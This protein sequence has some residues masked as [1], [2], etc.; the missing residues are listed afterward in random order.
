MVCYLIIAQLRCY[1]IYIE[2][3]N[4]VSCWV[5]RLRKKKIMCEFAELLIWKDSSFDP[6][7]LRLQVNLKMT[8]VYSI[9][10]YSILYRCFYSYFFVVTKGV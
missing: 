5:F 8:L 3:D 9:I 6:A 2:E 7:A 4:V 10:Q 1:F